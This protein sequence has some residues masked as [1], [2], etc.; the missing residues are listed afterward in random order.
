MEPA[1]LEDMNDLG[2]GLTPMELTGV[3]GYYGVLTVECRD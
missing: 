1:L 2:K 3:L